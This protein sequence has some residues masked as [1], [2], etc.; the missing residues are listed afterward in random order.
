MTYIF[1]PFGLMIY[2]VGL[3]GFMTY[4]FGLF[5]LM[6][7]M[8]SRIDDNTGLASNIDIHILTNRIDN[9]RPV[10]DM[11]SFTLHALTVDLKLTITV[12]FEIRIGQ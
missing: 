10:S 9:I 2:M 12:I 11:H 1:V 3:V 8:T 7:N 5:G 6:I 4:I